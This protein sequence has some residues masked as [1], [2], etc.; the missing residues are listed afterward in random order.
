MGDARVRLLID[1][2]KAK[3][4]R[5]LVYYHPHENEHGSAVIA[6]HQVRDFGGRLLEI[7]SQGERLITFRLKGLTYSFDPD[8]MFTDT[9][10]RR[11][12]IHSGAFV[13]DA[14]LAS[15]Q[16]LRNPVLSQLGKG[17]NPIVGV[18][19][20]AEDG[21]DVLSYQ[22]GGPMED[23]ALKVALNPKEKPHNFFV[24][25]DERLF[26]KLHHAGFNAVLQSPASPDDGS[27]AVYCRQ[28]KWPYVNVVAADSDI[29]QQQRM[30]KALP[31]AL[32]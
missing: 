13:T 17:R 32:A 3:R 20:N 25:L 1:E 9:G 2:V 30:L 10:L 16:A 24:V 23:H 15:A 14:A 29:A 4:A 26:L 11:S 6:R 12:L 27:L 19:N 8:R 7:R 28:R 31:A 22:K 18:Q 21:V 5:Y